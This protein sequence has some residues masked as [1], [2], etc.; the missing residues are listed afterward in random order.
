MGYRQTLSRLLLYLIRVFREQFT[1]MQHATHCSSTM[2]HRVSL[3]KQLYKTLTQ[4]LT[5]HKLMKCFHHYFAV[6]H[7]ATFKQTNQISNLDL[8]VE[9][10]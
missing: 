5:I 7:R 1:Q 3:I 4:H 10:H 9:T 8:A 6:L 2:P